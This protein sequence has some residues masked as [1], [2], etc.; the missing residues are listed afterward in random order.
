[1][2]DL[3]LI[4]SP[5][6][7]ERRQLEKIL[8]EG[9]YLVWEESNAVGGLMAMLEQHPSLIILDEDIPPVTAADVIQVLRQITTV[10]VMVIGNGD[11]PEEL[12]LLELGGD[13]YLRRPIMNDLLRARVRSLIRRRRGTARLASTLLPE[14]VELEAA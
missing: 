1:M 10:P 8:A 11:E 4:I 7:L 6:V 2:P 14:P 9:G 12:E 5:R 13:F 3:I